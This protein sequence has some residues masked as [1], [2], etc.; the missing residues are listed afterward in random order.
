MTYKNCTSFMVRIRGLEPPPPCEDQHLKLAR[1]PIPPYPLLFLCHLPDD[2]YIIARVSPNVNPF[3]KKLKKRVALFLCLLRGKICSTKGLDFCH[4]Q[5]Y[6]TDDKKLPEYGRTVFGEYLF[7]H[8]LSHRHAR[9]TRKQWRKKSRKGCIWERKGAE[10]PKIER[11]QVLRFS[12]GQCRKT[13]TFDEFEF[14]N[15]PYFMRIYGSLDSIRTYR[16]ITV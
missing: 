16:Q 11:K 14:R 1:L 12:L 8:S 13:Q 4:S 6:H 5:S 15:N 10:M 3:L 7:D 9:S 2:Y